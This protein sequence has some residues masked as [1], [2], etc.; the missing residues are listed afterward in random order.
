LE[1]RSLQVGAPAD[2]ILFDW[3]P[4]GAFQIRATIAAA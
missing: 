3:E 2:L 1:T 4:R